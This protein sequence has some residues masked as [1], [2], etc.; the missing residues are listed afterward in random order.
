MKKY[1]GTKLVQARP[2]T[3]GAYN[4][5]RG[6]EI[7]ADENPEDEGY[8]IQYPDGYVSWSPKG[9]FDHSYLEVDDNP[10]LPSGVSIGL[11]MVEAFIDQVEVMKL[12]ERTTVVRCILKNGFE[13][14]ESSACVDPRNYS[15]EI[16]KEAR[17][18]K[19]SDRTWN[20]LGF[21]IQTARM[22]VRQDESNNGRDLL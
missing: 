8:M 15:E 16:G 12:G 4:R 20:L 21:L 1:I 3:R 10:Q 18:E 2:M 14:V 19:I 13:L 7:P 22:G 9:M 17:L 11:G 6:W 5:Y